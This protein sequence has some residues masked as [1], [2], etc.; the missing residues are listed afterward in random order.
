MDSTSDSDDIYLLWLIVRPRSTRLNCSSKLELRLCI[1]PQKKTRVRDQCEWLYISRRRNKQKQEERKIAGHPSN[2]WI[3]QTILQ[4]VCP[5]LS[6]S[7]ITGLSKKENRGQ[8]M[9]FQK[10]SLS[11]CKYKNPNSF[12]LYSLRS[13][14]HLGDWSFT[15]PAICQLVDRA[16]AVAFKFRVLVEDFTWA[17]RWYEIIKLPHLLW[18]TASGAFLRSSFSLPLV[19][20]LG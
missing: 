12:W 10:S 1:S 14:V 20:Q 4:W 6:L 7:V 2:L 13:I 15:T 5:S 18:H 9:A 8:C 19:L 11:V 16:L 3:N 17:K